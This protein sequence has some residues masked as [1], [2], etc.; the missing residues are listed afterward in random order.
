[1]PVEV[2]E[3]TRFETLWQRFEHCVREPLSS[4]LAPEV[5]VVP[6]HGWSTWFQRE[7]LR[8]RSCLALFRFQPLGQ[9]MAELLAGILGPELAP[10]RE[11]DTLI[12]EVA[13][14]LPDLISDDDFGAVRAWLFAESSTLEPGRMIDLSRC[15]ASLFDRYLLQ[16]PE[17]IA[18]WEQGLDWFNPYESAPS[19][20]VWQRKL[21]RTITERRPFRSVQSMTDDLARLLDNGADQ[22]PERV[23]IWHV[24]ALSP[25]HLRFLETIGRHT[26][27]RLFLLVPAGAYWGDMRGRR[28]LLKQLRDSPLTLRQFCERHH[29]DVLH[30][31]LS[32][33]GSLSRR[34]QMLMV[35]CDGEPWQFQ[36]L[37]ENES[38]DDTASG[39]SGEAP[40]STH[41]KQAATGSL[42]HEL[43]QDLQAA[44]EPARRPLPDDG[45]IRVHSC[46]SALREIEVLHTELRAAFETDST[47]MPEDVVVLTPDLEAIAP[48]VQAVF[49]RSRTHEPGHIPFHLAGRSSRHAQPLVDAWSRLVE[50][51]PGR[52]PASEVL[53]FLALEPVRSA[54]GISAEEID[55]AIEW[56]RD[57]GI[58]W[59]LETTHRVQ[60]G[61]PETDLNTWRFGLDRLLLGHLMPPGGGRM[62]G[63]VLAL[64]RASGLKSALLGQIWEFIAKLQFWRSQTEIPRSLIDWQIP[65]SRMLP[66][67][68]DTTLDE[69][70]AR[71][72]HDAI[73]RLTKFG[74]EA[75]FNTPVAFDLVAREVRSLIEEAG[76]S[77]PFRVGGVLFCAMDAVRSLPAKVV[78]L[79]GMNDGCF[80][81]SDRPM[82]FDLM[83]RQP[84]PEDFSRRDLDRHLFLEA[85]LSA[86]RQLIITFT[87]QDIRDQ[88]HRPPSVVVDELLDALERTHQPVPQSSDVAGGRSD[89]F[90]TRLL[91]H[92]PLHA[93]S[94]A[95]FDGFDQRLRSFDS[96]A[97]LAARRLRS[98]MDE[99]TPFITAPLPPEDLVEVTVE[100]LIRLVEKPWWLLVDRLGLSLSDEAADESDR[101]PLLLDNLDEWKIGEAWLTQHRH[102]GSSGQMSSDLHR[103][104]ALPGG[105]L[106]QAV[107][108][109]LSGQA[110]AILA[111][112]AAENANQPPQRLTLDCEL[113]G[114][115]LLGTLRN[116]TESGLRRVTFSR[117]EARHAPRLWIEQLVATVARRQECPVAKAIGRDN[118]R[119]AIASIEPAAAETQLQKLIQ[120]WRLARRF[121]LAFYPARVIF[122]LLSK[123]PA[124]SQP[125]SMS[126]LQQEVWKELSSGR[127]GPGLDAGWNM[128]FARL[129]PVSMTLPGEFTAEDTAGLPGAVHEPILIRMTR[130]IA[131]PVHAA[132]ERTSD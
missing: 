115:R 57:S 114:V 61:L 90:R 17:L 52:L 89:D 44:F 100:E 28:Q 51:L 130:A 2:Y 1:M 64:D 125:E 43:Q 71:Q 54:A 129:D 86:R 11:K 34:Q 70:S 68:L 69:T 56:V 104:G 53:D 82:R 22:L 94:P 26:T 29:L 12:W 23:S 106:G 67:M 25:V 14:C 107:L 21:W 73:D 32:S 102:D 76:Q 36:E 15:I 20:A 126:K 38:D 78:A 84:R 103:S 119:L 99:T 128:L 35:D 80:P 39:R 42:L 31:L 93:F 112:A 120:L 131:V 9:W 121:P 27:V 72:I 65:L 109:S 79:V 49:G 124:L 105:S 48:L 110:G 10:Y 55:T 77:R 74:Q 75:G 91:V 45:S 3:A 123:D 6:A 85:I 18:A 97:L 59:G 88:R 66:Q 40:D 16:R 87:G 41:R 58:R 113:D 4:V 60:E 62:A 63:A 122:Q 30:P 117:I 37:I 96:Q 13:A 33:M 19:D 98:V 101:E 5:V 46:H 50:L 83:A 116:W 7:L 92:H 95:C 8:T 108:A 47:L 24:G 111:E 81:G 127:S 132:L 118:T